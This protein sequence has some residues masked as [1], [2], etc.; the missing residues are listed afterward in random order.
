MLRN[1]GLKNFKCWQTLDIDLAP[2]TL[3]FGTNSSGKTA[4]LQ[5]LLMLKQTA[6]GFDPKQHINFGGSDR[7]YVDLG[8]YLDLIFGHSSGKNIGVNLSW[9]T[10]TTVTSTL[11]PG[12]RESITL[13]SITYKVSWGFED[14]IYLDKLEYIV[15]SDDSAQ[16]SV[17]VC[18]E[19]D[20]EYSLTF[21]ISGEKDKP[22]IISSPAHS[23]AL[24]WHVLLN[25]KSKDRVPLFG[26]VEELE[27]FVDGVRYLGPLR[28]RPK[29]HYL[30]TGG[31]PGVLEP[32]GANTIQN[33]I[34][35]RRE[36]RIL[37]SHV[38][39]RLKKM[40]LVDAFDV[41][42][43]DQNERLYEATAT[44]GGI[45]TSLIDVG[46]GVS[47]VLPVITML[48]S[49]PEGSIVLL[50]QPELH[51]HPN[52]QS[53]LADLLLFAA[54]QRK[55]Q[56]IVESHSEHILRRLQ[57]RVAEA[58]PEFA[59]PAN[60]KMYFC[61]TGQEGSSIS[62]VEIDRFGQ[63]ANWPE[64]FL[65]DISGDIHSMARAALERRGQELER[66]GHRG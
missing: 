65:G 40:Y 29:R 44:I 23:Y 4:I 37:L 1:I 53:A 58:Q 39:R 55:L 52:A 35:S 5:S 45:E 66:V 41:K 47:Q 32:D 57:R 42:P 21:P 33:L 59:K 3:F 2:I 34:A 36:D 20:E 48:L 46:F 38:E 12:V 9:S 30:W 19:N 64:N 11:S 62:E 56:L 51:L 14:N 17:R 13:K 54:E 43:I 16:A 26:V 25:T 50:E 31:T 7:D 6:R 15:D 61:E 18:R 60:I 28:A 10:S 49:A 24:P 22:Q 8:S 63:I 27:Q